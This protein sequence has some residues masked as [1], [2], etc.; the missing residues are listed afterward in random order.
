MKREDFGLET[1]EPEIQSGAPV[2]KIKEM[3]K[4]E[5]PRERAI[6]HGIGS[7]TTAELLAIILRT[8]QQGFPITD[9]CRQLMSDNDNSLLRLARRSRRELTLTK[10][11]G[12]AKALQVEAMMEITRRYHLELV[13]STTRVLDSLKTSDSIFQRMRYRIAN[14]DHEEV[15]ILL[16]NRMNQV[17]KEFKLTSG[18]S[19]ASVFDT[20]MIL[21]RALL[22]NAEGIVMCHNH[23]SGNLRPSPQD[24]NI[25]RKL[26]GACSTMDIRMID[27][28][29]VTV[30]GFYSYADEGRLG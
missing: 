27:H 7:L 17:I 9:L 24:D 14:L 15:W 12:D 28:V 25:T 13:D 29:I 3:S 26:F 2:L 5:R 8:G 16:L 23:P 4:E 10:G 19:I 20:K 30:N 18:S 22:E 11:I 6:N 1:R 21:K